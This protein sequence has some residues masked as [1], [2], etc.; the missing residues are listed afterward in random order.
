[1]RNRL[2]RRCYVGRQILALVGIENREA[3]EERDRVRLV[4]GFRRACPFAVG[5][6]AVGIDETNALFAL[7]DMRADFERLPE[8]EPFLGG[9]AA[10]G[11]GDPE[12]EDVDARIKAAGGGV[13]WKAKRGC[14][15]GDIARPRLH[16]RHATLFELGDDLGGDLLIQAA[17]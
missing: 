13:A 11:A 5:N 15:A 7:A 10:L 8:R 12:D 6:E 1:M 4:A 16:P 9:E 3:L 2:R 17:A 14:D